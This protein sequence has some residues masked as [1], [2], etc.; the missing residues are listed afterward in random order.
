MMNHDAYVIALKIGY[1]T[2]P[3]V[4]LVT[5]ECGVGLKKKVYLHVQYMYM[6]MDKHVL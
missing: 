3:P 6:C 1:N 2:S 5:P 4:Y